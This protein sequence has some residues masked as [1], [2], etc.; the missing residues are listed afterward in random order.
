MEIPASFPQNS[1]DHIRAL[2]VWRKD[3]KSRHQIRIRS[4][5]H[6]EKGPPAEADGPYV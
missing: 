5:C 4:L 6:S 1:S 3:G 2:F